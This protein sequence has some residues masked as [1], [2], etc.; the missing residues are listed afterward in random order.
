MLYY[1]RISRKS[2]ITAYHVWDEEDLKIGNKIKL[3]FNDNQD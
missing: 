3:I 2:L 1:K